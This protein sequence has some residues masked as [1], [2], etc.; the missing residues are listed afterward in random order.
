MEEPA[1]K[2]LMSARA[3]FGLCRGTS[4]PAPLTATKAYDLDSHEEPSGPQHGR[5]IL[6]YSSEQAYIEPLLIINYLGSKSEDSDKGSCHLTECEKA[7]FPLPLHKQWMNIQLLGFLSYD[8][9][10]SRSDHRR[11]CFAGCANDIGNDFL[12]AVPKSMV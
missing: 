12:F 5:V 8:E 4:C 7:Q 1:R 9:V 3:S 11:A 6:P 10:A 2:D